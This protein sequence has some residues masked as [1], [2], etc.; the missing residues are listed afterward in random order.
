M[1]SVLVNV[2]PKKAPKDA[3][4]ICTTAALDSLILTE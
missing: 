2:D 3:D 4:G 1:A